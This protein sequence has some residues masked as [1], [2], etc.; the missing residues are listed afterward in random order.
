MSFTVRLNH[1]KIVIPLK[2]L[3]ED[4]LTCFPAAGN[5]PRKGIN[6][7][8]EK[9]IKH[10]LGSIW[11]IEKLCFPHAG[12]DLESRIEVSGCS[13]RR[14]QIPVCVFSKLRNCNP[15]NSNTQIGHCVTVLCTAWLLRHCTTE[16]PSLHVYCVNRASLILVPPPYMRSESRTVK[17]SAL[18][19]LLPIIGAGDW[20]YLYFT[21][22]TWQDM[23]TG[24]PGLFKRRRFKRIALYL[25]VSH[26]TIGA[27]SACFCG[28]CITGF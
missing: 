28:V 6:I 1:N 23:V 8:T 24:A 3:K 5:E 20:S 4:N 17:A 25:W 15:R 7:L 2:K 13:L 27:L 22:Y 12:R 10:T 21:E 16:W 18:K 9:V 19:M 26:W 11:V 14:P